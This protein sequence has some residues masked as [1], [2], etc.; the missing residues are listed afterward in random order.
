MKHNEYIEAYAKWQQVFSEAHKALP[1][2]PLRPSMRTKSRFMNIIAGEGLDNICIYPTSDGTKGFH[3][4]KEDALDL[5][6]WIIE[7]YS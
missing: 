5:A 2:P 6:N 7:Y 3:I 1:T 4:S